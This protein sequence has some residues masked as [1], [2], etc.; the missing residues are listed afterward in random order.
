MLSIKKYIHFSYTNYYFFH[1]NKLE[2]GKFIKF[3]KFMKYNNYTLGTLK[4][5]LMKTLFEQII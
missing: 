3:Q 4:L 5:F 2:I 1:L